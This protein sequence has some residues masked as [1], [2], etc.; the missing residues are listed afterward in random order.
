MTSQPPD[1]PVDVPAERPA[2]LDRLDVLI[3]QW[4]MEAT[5]PAGYY[6]PGSPEMTARG[7][8]ATFDWVEG[9]FFLTQRFVV[10]HPTA[11]SGIAIIGLGGEPGT[12]AQ[13]YYD[14][15]G[16]SR[17]YQMSLDDGIW[18]LWR[19]APGFCQRYTGRISSDGNAITGAWEGSADGQEW[20][21][22]FGLRYLRVS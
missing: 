8:R 14:S 18:Q 7:G 19:Y 22:D 20:K 21:H 6:G 3:G 16:V 2:S 17:V 11:P 1:T 4:D 15:R 13:H 9:R 12:F 5:F 10:D